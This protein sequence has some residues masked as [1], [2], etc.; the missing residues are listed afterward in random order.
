MARF[1]YQQ[2]S[3]HRKRIRFFTMT[4]AVFLVLSSCID[5]PPTHPE[6]NDYQSYIDMVWELYDQKYVAFDEKNV[7]WNAVHDLYSQMAENI[8]SFGELNDLM[9]EMIET[10]EDKNAL[11]VDL[12]CHYDPSYIPTYSPDIEVNYADSVMMELLEPW[13]FQWDSSMGVMWGHC[14]I[15]TIPYFAIKHFAYFFT[16][17]HFSNELKNHLDAPGM[18]I[19]IRMSDGVSLVPAEQIPC[20]FTTQSI[21]AFFTQHRTGPEHDDRS[22]R[23]IHESSPRPWAY[24][25][26]IVLLMGEQNFGAAEAF[27]SAMSQMSY[28][29]IIGDTTGGGG[30]IPGY[31]TQIFWPVWEDMGIICP[32]ARVLTADTVSIEGNGILPDIYVQTTPA[33]FQSGHDP[34]L[35]Y[36]IEWI[37]GETAH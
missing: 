7:D 27:A 22:A 28:V 34:V 9:I 8:N 32:F 24:T 14:V 17:I 16:Y 20:L 2:R 23:S 15:D 37:A 11:L 25:K 3:E 26:P 35:E 30:N 1:M 19:D 18:I 10:L 36:A 6:I 29:T 31:F 33:D 21:T 5:D 4:I 12:E 13:H